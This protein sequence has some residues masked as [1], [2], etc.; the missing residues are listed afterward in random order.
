MLLI[1]I[2]MLLAA[3]RGGNIRIEVL[4]WHG[5]FVDCPDEY[6]RTPLL[7]ASQMG[8]L[9]IVRLLLERGAN[10]NARDASHTMPLPEASQHGYLDINI[11][12]IAIWGTQSCTATNGTG[13]CRQQSGHLELD[14]IT[15]SF[16][17]RLPQ[18]R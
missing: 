11:A 3:Q 1:P 7:C 10:A 12:G 18:C 9:D 16:W 4:L 2:A 5:A 17:M 14:G 6:N 15:R 13:C 8:Q